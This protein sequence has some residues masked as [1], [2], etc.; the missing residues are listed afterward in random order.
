MY[1]HK[2]VAKLGKRGPEG[3]SSLDRIKKDIRTVFTN[4]LLYNDEVNGNIVFLAT[5]ADVICLA[6][7]QRAYWQKKATEHLGQY[8]QRQ[9]CVKSFVEF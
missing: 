5:I 7:K 3:Y 6:L 2:I 8:L 4:S 9:G 1:L